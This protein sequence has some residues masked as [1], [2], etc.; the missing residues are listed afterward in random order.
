MASVNMII[1]SSLYCGIKPPVIN[2][3]KNTM[4]NNHK[5][6]NFKSLILN[7]PKFNGILYR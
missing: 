1:D 7:P 4:L 2:P 5:P 3:P 6:I